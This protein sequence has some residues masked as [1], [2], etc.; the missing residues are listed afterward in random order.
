MP[1]VSEKGPELRPYRHGEIGTL[2][3]FRGFGHT[4]A[5]ASRGMWALSAGGGGSLGRG[6]QGLRGGETVIPCEKL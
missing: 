2:F 4:A 5:T 1:H 3:G 6:L